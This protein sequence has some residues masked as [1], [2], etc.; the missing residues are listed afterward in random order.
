MVETVR[1]IKVLLV[2]D[3]PGDAD[4][5]MEYLTSNERRRY[6]LTGVDNLAAALAA[7][8]ARSFDIVLLDLSLPDSTGLDTVQGVIASFPQVTIVVLTG[9]A[10]E[11]VA[12]QAMRSG[13]QDY[14][15][16]NQITPALLQRTISYAIE[17]REVL[18][19]KEKLLAELS[20]ALEQ[21]ET[22]RGILPICASCK[23]IRDED[24]QWHHIESYIRSRSQAEFSHGICPECLKKLYPEYL[25]QKK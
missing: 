9:L 22:L 4:L 13:A 15:E 16:K 10:D 5:I 14:L 21:I 6:Q 20:T 17:R 25:N 7:L 18:R 24:N 12:L 8:G 1:E 23:K 11:D 3:N 19:E 2:E